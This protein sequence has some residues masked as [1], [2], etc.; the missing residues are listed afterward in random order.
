MSSDAGAGAKRS[1][2]NAVFAEAVILPSKRYINIK[3]ACVNFGEVKYTNAR[4]RQETNELKKPV[5]RKEIKK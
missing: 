5:K 4:D 2:E 1:S 3:R